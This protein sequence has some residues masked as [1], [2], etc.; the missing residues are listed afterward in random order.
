MQK[1]A[2][3]VQLRKNSTHFHPRKEESKD[4]EGKERVTW[5]RGGRGMMGKEDEKWLVG[6]SPQHI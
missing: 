5:V 3:A 2:T 4:I 1:K 6:T